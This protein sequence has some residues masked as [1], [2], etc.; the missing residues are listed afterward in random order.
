MDYE[1]KPAWILKLYSGQKVTEDVAKTHLIKQVQD[2]QK[3]LQWIDF[4][5]EWEESRREDQQQKL[6]LREIMK[7]S[8]NR[9]TCL[10][11]HLGASNT[12]PRILWIGISFWCLTVLLGWARRALCKH[13]W[14]GVLKRL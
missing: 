7:Q 3:Y 10:S 2:P 14:S 5:K 13:L 1:V 8:K 6:V 9:A 4:A 12:I 11:S